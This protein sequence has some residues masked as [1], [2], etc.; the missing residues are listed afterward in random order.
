MI[1]INYK[2]LVLPN[3]ELRKVCITFA[4]QGY[5]PPYLDRESNQVMQR[6]IYNVMKSIRR[7]EMP[8]RIQLIVDLCWFNCTDEVW[9]QGLN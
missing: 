7:S 3:K 2:P 6:A 8:P 5:L 9:L 1:P 4:E